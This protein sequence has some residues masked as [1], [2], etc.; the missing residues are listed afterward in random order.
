[1]HKLLALGLLLTACASGPTA[2][3]TLPKLR[4]AIDQ[5]VESPEQNAEHSEL[6]EQVSE[7]RMLHGLARSEVE[8]Q[9]GSGDPCSRHPLCA[10]RGFEDQDRYYEIGQPGSAYV[11]RY[12]PALIV[13]Y[14][15][16]G[17]VERTFVLRAQ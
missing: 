3:Q 12:R 9:I 15:R 5:K 10:E 17:K 4:A 8:K 13:G 2:Q 14:N 1:M 7:G 11:V 6:A 16:F